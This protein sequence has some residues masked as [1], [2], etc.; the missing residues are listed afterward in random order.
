MKTSIKNI[1]YIGYVLVRIKRALCFVLFPGKTTRSSNPATD[2]PVHPRAPEKIFNFFNLYTE[3]VSN[4]VPLH[5]IRDVFS[6]KKYGAL[7]NRNDNSGYHQNVLPIFKGKSIYF[8]DDNKWDSA[9]IYFMIGLGYTYQDQLCRLF[10]MR[11]QCYILE[12][13]FLRSVCPVSMSKNK[14]IPQHFFLSISYLVDSKSPHFVPALISSLEDSINSTTE[15]T[16]IDRERCQKVMK[17][18][19]DNNLSKYNCQPEKEPNLPK[20]GR[21]NV[22]VVDQAYMDFSVVAS[23]GT[24]DSFTCMLNKAIEDNQGA[25]IIV[26][27]HVD[28]YSRD[29]YFT[30][31]NLPENVI[32]YSEQINPISLL[33]MVDKVYTYSSTMGF[34]ALMCGKAVYTFGSPIYAGWGITHDHRNFSGRRKVKRTL[35]ELFYFIYIKNS[36][37]IDPLKKE[38]TDI[39]TAVNC[40]INMRKEFFEKGFADV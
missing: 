8:I 10:F 5:D 15:I 39:E 36:I 13:N 30:K 19:V 17:S 12:E 6:A 35:E 9:E 32:L 1:P 28:K 18:I 25:N 4:N 27:T 11:K 16:S 38:L 31:L 3:V 26:K 29:T 24:D 34:E 21:K 37:Y 22:L 7:L 33:K 14:L 20:N 2:K 40:L 23:G